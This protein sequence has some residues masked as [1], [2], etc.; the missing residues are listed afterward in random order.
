M[1]FILSVLILLVNCVCWATASLAHSGAGSYDPE[2]GITTELADKFFIDKE[3][4]YLQ[5]QAEHKQIA[6]RTWH[7]ARQAC[8]DI[9]NHRITDGSWV[10]AMNKAENLLS[11]PEKPREFELIP[12]DY[13]VYSLFIIP[14]KSWSRKDELSQLK[15]VFQNFGDAIGNS[16]L[17]IWLEDEKTGVDINRS[18]WYCDLLRLSYNDGPYVVTTRHRPDQ[19]KQGEEIVLINLSGISVGRAEKVLN[20]LEEDMRKNSLS[21]RRAL[22]FEEVKQRLLTML[23][24]QGGALK[25]AVSILKW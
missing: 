15:E 24:E 10:S 17:A 22:I 5:K 11:A 8:D 4:E 19:I 14:N 21:K 12:N 2:T 25:V 9:N 16:R 20:V 3:C 18:K 1:R 23:E 13:G 7:F 6:E